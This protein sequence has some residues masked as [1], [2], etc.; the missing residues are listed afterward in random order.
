MLVTHPLQ[1]RDKGA[2]RKDQ[3][4]L[5]EGWGGSNIHSVRSLFQLEGIS[6][7][8]Y[9]TFRERFV[10]IQKRYVFILD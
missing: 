1:N 2:G 3:E 8:I 6:A 9:G 4:C 7:G 10:N 5:Q